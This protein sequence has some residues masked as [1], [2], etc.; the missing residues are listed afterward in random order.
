MSR[1]PLAQAV[2]KISVL[3]EIIYSLE[4]RINQSRKLFTFLPDTSAH[5]KL[6]IFIRQ[7]S[8]SYGEQITM[9]FVAE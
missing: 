5:Q 9:V 3:A 4:I 7:S 2:Q 1:V 6:H 8:S